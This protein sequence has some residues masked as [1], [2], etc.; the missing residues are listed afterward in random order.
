[1]TPFTKGFFNGL[2]LMSTLIFLISCH[3]DFKEN[4]RFDKEMYQKPATFT[5]LSSKPNIVMFLAD[6][7]GYEVPSYSGGQSYQTPNLDS[8]AFNGMQFSHCF[9]T[10]NCCPSRVELL[11][12]KYNFRNY[13]DWGVFDLSQKTFVNYL[14]EAGYATCVAGKWQFGN[15]DTAAKQMGFDKYLLFDPFTEPDDNGG[16]ERYKN[17]TLYENGAYLP[18][19]QTNGKYAD[20][21]FVN[22]ISEFI[23][24][25]KSKP[26]FVYYPLSLCHIPFSPT[27]DD[28]QYAAW[29]PLTDK[30][31]KK[32]FPSMVKYMD[33][34]IGEVMHKIASAGLS[35]NTIFVFSGDN[36]TPPSIVSQFK[37][38]TIDGGKY[39]P[40]E[41]GVHVPLIVSN[42]SRI[43]PGTIQPAIVDYSD[44]FTTFTDLAGIPSLKLI[45]AGTLDSKS[46]YPY[47]VSDSSS[48]ARTWSYC[49]WKP[50]LTV[51]KQN[52]HFVQDLT[53]KL[54]DSTNAN[55]FYNI[56]SDSLEKT[57]LKAYQLTPEEKK[58]KKNFQTIIAAMHN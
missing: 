9:A 42:P 33:K 58:I 45:M 53:Y 36:G 56:F 52:K 27:P 43:A 17:P 12:G 2:W 40:T 6:D 25:N 23:D 37:G 4:S 54:Y 15:G 13:I 20:D 55:K 8:L 5:S 49:Y 22:Y 28:P 48:N 1:M 41:F 3:K 32:Y 18:K 10:P 21:M 47:L 26:F 51:P 44:F 11:S 19:S 57:P 16:K 14:N 31:N 35:Q 34:K 46:F 30:S 50:D 29:N 24:S 39:T 38:R 7:I